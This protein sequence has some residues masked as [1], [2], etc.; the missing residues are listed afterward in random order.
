M[1]FQHWKAFGV[2]LMGFGGVFFQDVQQLHKKETWTVDTDDE[3]GG[4]TQLVNYSFTTPHF[5]SVYK[6]KGPNH[7]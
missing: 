5:Y 6:C 4:T 1:K 7:T 3:S 2:S